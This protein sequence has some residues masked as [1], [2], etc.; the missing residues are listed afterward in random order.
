MRPYRIGTSSGTR[1][2][3]C[4]SSRSIGSSRKLGS[5]TAWASSGTSLRAALPLAFRS[6]TVRCAIVAGGPPALPLA[7]AWSESALGVVTPVM[8]GFV[9]SMSTS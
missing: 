8:P 3:A 6:S 5:N 1:V 7:V 9:T 2:V 4:S